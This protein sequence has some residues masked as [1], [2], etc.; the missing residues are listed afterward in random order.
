MR[1]IAFLTGSRGEWGYIRPILRL[2][3]ADAELDYSVIAT[4]MHLLSGFGMSVDEIESDGFRVDERIFMTLDGYTGTTMAKSLGLLLL[5]LPGVLQRLQPGIV[6]LAGDRGEPLMGAIAC[7]PKCGR[8]G[9]DTRGSANHA[10]DGLDEA[11]VNRHNRSSTSRVRWS[12]DS[13]DHSGELA[14][15]LGSTCHMSR[16]LTCNRRGSVLW[17]RQPEMNVATT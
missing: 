3:Q 2:I 17:L 4:N 5:E 13:D 8:A 1:R 10:R 15:W 7:S 14:R 12:D 9:G 11:A 16:P 6:V